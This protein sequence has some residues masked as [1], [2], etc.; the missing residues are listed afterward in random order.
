ME[1]L[2]EIGEIG[3]RKAHCGK[4]G[5]NW[6]NRSGKIGVGQIGLPENATAKQS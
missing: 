4:V 3:G 6:R 1:K 2:G 5:R